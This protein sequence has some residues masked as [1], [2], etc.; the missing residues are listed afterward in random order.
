MWP[1]TNESPMSRSAL[2]RGNKQANVVLHPHKELW[3]TLPASLPPTFISSRLSW[4]SRKWVLHMSM[5]HII[6]RTALKCQHELLCHFRAQPVT[7]SE[8]PGHSAYG[9]LNGGIHSNG[10]GRQGTPRTMR[11]PNGRLPIQAPRRLGARFRQECA[12]GRGCRTMR[13][14]L[15]TRPPTE[16]SS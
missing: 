9:P 6:T 13:Y 1:I 14:I 3:L 10:T 5:H 16:T 8:I 2:A 7:L 15:S 11:S 4:N 12:G